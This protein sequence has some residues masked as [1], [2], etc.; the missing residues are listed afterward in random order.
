[1]VRAKGGKLPET[2]M[3]CHLGA[4]SQPPRSVNA[5]VAP[6]RPM[7]P[8]RV[9]A[10]RSSVPE[11]RAS[12]AGKRVMNFGIVQQNRHAQ[13]RQEHQGDKARER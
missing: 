11:G 6:T 1:M 10:R 9:N 4:P 3:A 5:S 13:D 8:R 2:S 7:A 12:E